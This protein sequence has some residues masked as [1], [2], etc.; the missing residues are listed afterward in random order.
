MR[1]FRK[2]LPRFVRSRKLEFSTILATVL[3]RVASHRGERNEGH[4]FGFGHYRDGIRVVSAP[5][6]S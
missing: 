6:W 2:F 1:E 3:H 4:G 5:G